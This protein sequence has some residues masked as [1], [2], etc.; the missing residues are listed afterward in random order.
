MHCFSVP[1]ASKNVNLEHVPTLRFSKLLAMLTFLFFEQVT[2]PEER[3]TQGVSVGLIIVRDGMDPL[4]VAVVLEN[5]I[6]L[7][8]IHDLSK[9]MSLLMGLL[10]VLN[11][12]YPKELRY[13]FE[14]I[15]KILMNIGAENCSAK[16]HGL[17]NKLFRTTE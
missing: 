3:M 1:C 10:Y 7:H 13:T 11:I 16:I 14:V 5:E 2:E 12:D 17:R 6:L 9:A 15:Q 8:E 4:D